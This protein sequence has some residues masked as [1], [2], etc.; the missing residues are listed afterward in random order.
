MELI[1]SD[2]ELMLRFYQNALYL[3][4]L[5]MSIAA[6]GCGC[7]YAFLVYTECY[8]GSHR[9]VKVSP[10]T[11]PESGLSP[12]PPTCLQRRTSARQLVPTLQ[13]STAST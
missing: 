9:K 7:A 5:V 12:C 6:L 10:R 3:I 11:A 13:S 8:S 1:T 2:P 4:S